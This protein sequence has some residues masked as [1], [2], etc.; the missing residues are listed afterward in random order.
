MITA[1]SKSF[2]YCPANGS[3]SIQVGKLHEGDFIFWLK[4]SDEAI[5]KCASILIREFGNEL[6]ISNIESS[7]N[8]IL[9]FSS[10]AFNAIDADFFSLN[11]EGKSVDDILSENH[12]S[13]LGIMFDDYI[14]S[15]RK[16]QPYLYTLRYSN[17]KGVINLS[18]NIYIYGFGEVYKLLDD[19]KNKSG[20]EIPRDLLAEEYIQNDPI[21]KYFR[22][23]DASAVLIY[24]YSKEEAII[25]INR[26]F[27]ALCINV[28]F[29]FKINMLDV[30][31]RM[32]SFEKTK[33]HTSKFRVNIP[34]VYKLNIT[35]LVIDNLVKIF[36][37]SNKRINSALSFISHGWTND[38]RERFLNQFIALDALYGTANGN[39][40]SIKGGVCRDAIAID[41]IQSKIEI[42]YDLRCKLI[43]GE[44]SELSDHGKYLK[45]VDMHGIDPIY[46]LFEI[47]KEC[48]LN[49]GG[50][51]ERK[52][53][54]K[55]KVMHVPVALIPE[56]TKMIELHKNN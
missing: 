54:I 50:L 23:P 28:D 3:P 39:K 52:I 51:Y 31:N 53:D 36:S 29:P 10:Y 32:N 56:V 8:I 49:Y 15:E 48:V 38:K 45:F 14:K 17:A 55:T 27:G 9:K 25:L 16:L 7:K 37:S 12:K 19:I 47:L 18:D 6:G 46:S 11:S 30:D 1:L 5:N 40:A 22:L 43:H 2:F 26:L 13:N 33:L 44:I 34:A 4:Y 24:A 42:I 41:S 20:I 35:P 21:G